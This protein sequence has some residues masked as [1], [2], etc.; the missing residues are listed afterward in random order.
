MSEAPAPV[1]SGSG[2]VSTGRRVSEESDHGKGSG[3]NKV[4]FT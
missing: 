3:T 4:Y 1:A 2:E